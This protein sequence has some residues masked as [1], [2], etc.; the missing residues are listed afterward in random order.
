MAGV[1]NLRVTPDELKAKAK[2]AEDAVSRMKGDFN[3][4]N[5]AINS[6]H[7]YW[8]GRA[9]DLHRKLYN[10]KA[11]EIQQILNMLGAYATDLLQMAGIYETAENKNK[12]AA[13]SLND[14]FI[15]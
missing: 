2:E 13:L 8:E 14:S 15:Y 5:T 12:A 6:T 1:I 7:S 9:G 10:D 4:L 11:E 3:K